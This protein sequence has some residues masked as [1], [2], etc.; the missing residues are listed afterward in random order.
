MTG[1]EA[2]FLLLT[3]QLGNPDRK[4]LTTA[5]LRILANRVKAASK[6]S[7]HRDLMQKDLLSLG[8]GREMADRILRLLEEEELLHYY[9]RRGEKRGCYPLTR[10]TAGYPG[11]LW[12]KLGEETPGCLWYKGDLSLLS[13][14]LVALVGSRDLQE[15]NR[16]FAAEVGRQAAIQG[17]VLVSGNAR[18]ADQTAQNA[19]LRAGGKVISVIAD[20]LEEKKIRDD[21]LYLSEDGF[22]CPFSPQRAI[23]RNRII[24]AM[25]ERTFVAQAGLYSGGTWDGTAK[26]LRHEWSKVFCFSDGSDAIKEFVQMGAEPILESELQNFD[27]LSQGTAG[28]LNQ[29]WEEQP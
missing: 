12:R 10:L 5:Q 23:S 19:C 8:Y 16:R 26:N 1:A 15:P 4:P 22:D 9:C 3:S 18:G 29:N 14:P 7:T 24:H 17:Y 25:A 27:A 2:G 28:F 21:V 20:S 6:D 13:Q 11:S